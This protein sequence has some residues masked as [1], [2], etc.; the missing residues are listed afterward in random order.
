MKWFKVATAGITADGREIKAQWLTDIAETYDKAKYTAR[1]WLEHMRGMSPSS[2]FN[3]VGTVEA[4]KV[5]EVDGKTTL[6]AQ[7]TP[8]ESL[9]TLNQEGKKISPS[10]EVNVDFAGSGKAYLDGLGV[11]DSPASLYTDVLKFSAASNFTQPLRGAGNQVFHQTADW[12]DIDF[13]TVFDGD[14]TTKTTQAT[15]SDEANKTNLFAKIK[16]VVAD[17][18]AKN[19][20]K[21][22]DSG[23]L[24]EFA[25]TLSDAVADEFATFGKKIEDKFNADLDAANQRITQLE[26]DLADAKNAAQKTAGEFATHRQVAT[27]GSPSDKQKAD[28]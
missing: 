22:I 25:S 14:D 11:T 24:T 19:R 26:Q 5:E 8:S 17:S 15:Q 7:I 6:F 23:V 21:S 20:D 28:C 27:G 1:V 16:Q 9:K 10:I 3:A 18:F 4:V 12:S 2:E 13:A